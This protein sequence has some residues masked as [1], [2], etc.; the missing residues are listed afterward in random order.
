[1]DNKYNIRSIKSREF[2]KKMVSSMLCLCR[3]F[4]LPIPFAG[5]TMVMSM[6][7]TC[8]RDFLR[9]MHEIYLV[10]NSS[11]EEFIKK[12]ISPKKQNEAIREASEK[13][14]MG[15]AYEPEYHLSEIKRLVDSLGK[16]TA[17]IQSSYKD[18]SALK[19][20]ERG[21]FEINFNLLDHPDERKDLFEI[22]QLARDSHCIKIFKDSIEDNK[23]SFRL[24]KLFAPKFNFSY[25]GSYY[26]VFLRSDVLLNLCR[27]KDQ[28]MVKQI[29]SR[30]INQINKFKNQQTLEK[31]EVDN[32]D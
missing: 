4:R 26:I 31:W 13:R 20:T 28:S 29:E 19:N 32:V 16:I 18:L 24:H 25:R 17:E 7:D 30:E 8:I 14:Y 15:V 2:R 5:Y 22:I 1:M 11:A 21:I 27:E 3:E 12:Q 23:I 9:I 6:S 10:E